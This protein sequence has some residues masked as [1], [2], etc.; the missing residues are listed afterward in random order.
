MLAPHAPLNSAGLFN[1]GEIFT[2]LAL[3]NEVA[4]DIPL[5]LNLNTI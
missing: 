4:V 3:W 5:G 2:R 1:R